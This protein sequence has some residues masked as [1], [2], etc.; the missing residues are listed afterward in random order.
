[1]LYRIDVNVVY[2]PLQIGVISN[3]MLPEA[4]LPNA[5]ITMLAS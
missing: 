1:M 4:P 5:R 2:M 3:P